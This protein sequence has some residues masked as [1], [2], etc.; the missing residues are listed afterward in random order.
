MNN[1]N[2]N[3]WYET[4]DPNFI[5]I[6]H[7]SLIPD[8]WISHHAI[9]QSKFSNSILRPINRYVEF[10]YPMPELLSIEKNKAIL[11]QKSHAEI[12]LLETIDGFRNIDR[13][14][15]RQYYQTKLWYP[16]DP[17]CFHPVYL[18]YVPW[19]I[20][21]DA[22]IRI[23]EATESSPVRIYPTAFSYQKMLNNP[24]YIEPAFV[25]FRFKRVGDHMQ[26]KNFGKIP[27]QSNIFDIH[28][29]AS[30]IIINKIKDF[31]E[32]NNV[33]SV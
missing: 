33:L 15:M 9:T 24:R 27:R 6:S 10:L 23:E 17:E 3:L 25:P 28:I 26:S 5:E 29:S 31:Y 7:K 1:F 30:D 13:P 2:F 20:D 19:F 11:R 16:K 14:W 8:K 12:F 32:K 18:F 22:D 4:Y 21:G